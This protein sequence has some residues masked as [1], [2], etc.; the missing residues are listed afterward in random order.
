M[1]CGF[2]QIYFFSWTKGHIL[3]LQYLFVD[4]IQMATQAELQL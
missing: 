2:Q 1:Q 3:T 4:L